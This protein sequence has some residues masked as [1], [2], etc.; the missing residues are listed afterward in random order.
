MQSCALR[1]T[2]KF[3]R[4]ENSFKHYFL[5]KLLGA[6]NLPNSRSEST[7]A[8]RGEKKAH[9]SAETSAARLASVECASASK[10]RGSN[11]KIKNLQTNSFNDSRRA[12]DFQQS[13]AFAT[14]DRE[15]VKL[16]IIN[17]HASSMLNTLAVCAIRSAVV[18]CFFHSLHD[19]RL[20]AIFA[21]T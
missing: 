16:K 9:N 2:R 17:T 4:L 6:P 11:N 13:S 20:M 5:A 21:K 18:F 3:N 7:L 15:T 1:A 14:S 10:W 19:K 12:G 8:V